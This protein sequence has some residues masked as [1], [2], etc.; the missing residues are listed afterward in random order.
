ML[1]EVDNPSSFEFGNI[2]VIKGA[3][4]NENIGGFPILSHDE[5]GV[6][7]ANSHAAQADYAKKWEERRP[8]LKDKIKPVPVPKRTSDTGMEEF[9][10]LLEQVKKDP[11][12]SV[13]V[14]SVRKSGVFVRGDVVILKSGGPPMTVDRVSNNGEDVRCTWFIHVHAPIAS[15]AAF[16]RD[17]LAPVQKS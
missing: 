8:P 7:V 13:G 4:H 14:E 10:D 2:L 16:H 6:Y 5:I 15:Q 9:A 3:K 1:V 17:L 11:D 12:F